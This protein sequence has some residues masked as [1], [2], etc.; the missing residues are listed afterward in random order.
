M[1]NNISQSDEP[2]ISLL[3]ILCYYYLSV[4]LKMDIGRPREDHGAKIRVWGFKR[5]ENF[6]NAL[7]GA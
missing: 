7:H 5:P 3:V 4:Q 2:I 6:K 1:K